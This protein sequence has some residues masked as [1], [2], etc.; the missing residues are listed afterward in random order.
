MY[1]VGI[2]SG[3]ITFVAIYML[4]QMTLLSLYVSNYLQTKYGALNVPAMQE[5]AITA[6]IFAGIC[7]SLAIVAL[8]EKDI[9]K[10]WDLGT[11]SSKVSV[12]DYVPGI[13]GTLF[14]FVDKIISAFA[15][16]IVGF[17]L[18]RVG[19]KA[20]LPQV[21]DPSS[22]TIFWLAMF[23]YLGLPILGWI[24]SLIAMKFYPLTNEKMS[25]I[26][27]EL[28]KRKDKK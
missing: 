4:L 5:F 27:A 22:N 11:K 18:A 6:I 9:P 24:A 17:L 19:Y 2:E 20:S 14:S 13:I 23:I 21:G 10:N 1:F 26:Q 3:T 15:T 25:E 28:A 16:T 7:T 8:W 12:K